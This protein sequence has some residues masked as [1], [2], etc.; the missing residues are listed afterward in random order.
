M[1]QDMSTTYGIKKQVTRLMAGSS[2]TLS[3]LMSML[4]VSLE[5]AWSMAR[6]WLKPRVAISLLLLFIVG[7]GNVWGQDYSGVYY[8]VG[9]STNGYDAGNPANNFYM[10]PTVGYKFYDSVNENYTDTDNG[11][12]FITTYKCR[13][14]AGYDSQEAVWIIEKHPTQDYYYIKHASDGKYLTYNPALFSDNVGRVRVHLETSHNNDDDAALFAIE[15]V[16]NKSSYDIKSKK[17]I[18]NSETRI[19][20]N[21]N[22]GNKQNL[23]GDGDPFDGVNTGGIIGLWTSGSSGDNN[24]KFYLESA[25]SIDAPTITNNNDGTFTITAASEATIYYTTD[26]STPTTTSYTGTG[27][28]SVNIDQTESM[29]VIKAIAKA[30]S[31]PFP[32]NVTTYY[33][34]VCERPVIS[35]SDGIVTITSTTEG[36]TIHYTTDGSPATS[37]S[38]VY[39]G[40]FAKGAASTFRAIA[41][42][43][44]YVTSSEAILLPPT[45]VSSSS[46]ITNMNGSYIL[47]SNF[48][49]SGSIGTADNPFKGIINGKLN[50]LTLGYPL[51]AYAD[52]AT[53]KNVILNNVNIS[54]SN[55]ND[56]GNA[57]AICCEATGD[58]RIYNCGVLSGSV[59]GG[60][61]VGGIVG[62]LDGRA[63]VINCYNYAEIN[64]GSNCGGI[65]GYNN[66]A[67]T[68]NNLQTMVMNCMNYGSV[69]GGNAAPI[70]GGAIIHNKYA[71]AD[72]TGLNNYC[73]FLY[74]EEKV[75]YVKTI[76]DDK[77]NGALGAEERFLNRFEFFRMTLNSTRNLAAFYVTGDATQKNEM[78]KW[79]LDKS[80]APYPILKAQAKYPSVVNPDAAH[81][82]AQ[83]DRN[84][85]GLLGTLSVTISGVGSGAVFSAPSGATITNGSLQ[86]NI[87]DKD[88]DNFNYNYRKVQLPYYNEVGTGNYTK[89]SD[90]TGR[91]VTGWKITS[92]TGGTPGS[93]KTDTYDYPSFNFVDRKCTNK[94]LYGTNGSNRVFAQGAYWEVPDGV[95]AIE[96]EPY[97]AK[98]VYL[99]DANY[100]MTYNISVSGSSATANKYGVTVC[101]SC[102]TTVNGQTVYN[103]ITTATN[104]LGSDASHTVYDYAVVLVGNYHQAANNAI[105]SIGKPLTFMSADL[106]GD[107]EPDNTL[108]YYHNQR[109]RV[110]EIRFDFLN[111]PGIGMVKRTHDATTAPEPGIFKPQG[112]F[113]ITNTV[114]IHC[115]Q[116]EYA[117]G[118]SGMDKTILAPLILQGGVY[119]QFVSGMDAAAKNTN[120]ILIGSNAWFKNFAN[121]C[122]TKNAQKTPK[123]PINVAGGDYTNFY[124]TGIYQPGANQDEE[125]AEC[126]IDGGRF[127]EVAGSGMQ[128]VKG[129]VTWLINAA[130]ITSFF[131][132]GIN[133][134]K[135]IT[136]SIRTTISNSYVDEFYG[137]PKFGDMSNTKTVTTNATDCHFGKFFGA[138]YG[139]TAYNRVGY[140][141]DNSANDTRDW[142]GYVGTHYGR[143]Y[144]A[145]NKGISTNYEYEFIPHSDGK[146]TVARFFVNYASLS[147]ASTRDVTNTLS[148][149]TIGTFYG[150][151]SLG[152][153]NGNINST[154]T[155]CKVTGSTFGAGFSASV[156][157]VEV[158]NK[159]AYLTPN[160]SYNRTANVYN[161]ANVKT[162]KDNNQF[163]VYTWS[164]TYGTNDE[165]FTD[166]EDGK[167]YIHTDV[168]LDGLGAV[169]GNVI[170]TINGNTVADENGKVM[171][172]DHSVYGGGEESAVNGNTS[173]T[174][175]GGTI[176]TTIGTTVLGGAEYGNVFGGGK[177]KEDDVTAG[178][179]KGTTEV[180]IRN[181]L[182][183]Q[184]YVDAHK[185][186]DPNLKVGDVLSSPTILH[187]VY[188]GGAYGSVG[189]FTYD[190]TSGMPT[191][192]ATAN[193]GKTVVTITGGTIGTDGNENGMVF[194]SSRGLEG[195]PETNA[196]VD[197]MAW[198]YDT[199]VT[200]GTLGSETGP[201]IKGSVYGGGENGHNFHDASVTVHSGTIGIVS[202]EKV[203]IGDIEYEGARY[204]NRGNVYGSGCG[205]DTYTGTDSK[206]YFGFNA[207]IVRGN[208]TV[209][210]DGGHV[211]HNVYG[212]G[213]MGSV[214]TYT[215]VDEAYNTAHPEATLPI[216]KPISCAANT[217]TCTV[218]VSGGQIGVAGA[219]MAGHGKGGPDDFGHVFGAGRGEMHDPKL[220]PNVET[221]AY[222]NKTILNISGTAFLTGSAYGGSESGHVLGNT[223]V[224]ISGGQIGCGKNATAPFDKVWADDYVPTAS[225]NLDCASWPFESPFAPYDPFANATGDL[226][227]YP[228]GKSTEGGRLE[229][230]DGHT[231]YGNVFG[232]GSGSVPYFDTT[233]GISKYLSTA[234]SVEGKTTINITGGHI[235]TNVYG[236]CEATNVKGSATITMTG[237]TVGV[238][239]TVAQIVAHPLTG[240]IFGAGKG[241]QRIFFNKETNVDRTFVN[242]EGGRVYGSIFGGGEDGHVFQN[243]TVNIGKDNDTTE[244][245]TIGTTGTSYVD[246]NVF[247]GGRGFGGEALTAGN[248]GGSVELNIKSGKILGSVYG[249]GRLASVGYGLYLVDEEITEGEGKVKPYGIL[250]PDDQYDGSY[251]DPSTDP[252][253]TYYNKG[254]GYITINIS[255]GT[256]GNDLEYIYNPTADQKAAIPYTTFD[257]QNH[258]Q[259]TKGG[260]VFTGGMG[261]LYALDNSTLLTLWPK[262]GKC[263]GT[264]LNMTGGIVKSS[265]YGGGEIG[266][267]EG[268]AT[269]NINGGTVGT[270]VVDSEDATK[271]YYFGSVFGGGK[272]S[273]ANVEGISEAGT[274]GGNVEVN[275]NKT[276]ASD[277]EAKGAIVNQVF[278]CNDM[279]GS[280]KGNVTVHVYA[281]QSPDGD[282]IS[283]KPTKGTETFDVMAVYGGGNL[284][285]YEPTD[286]E[287][288]KTT[289]IIDGCGLTSVRQVYGGGNAASTPATD[290]EVNGTYEILELFGGGNGF[291]KLPNGDSNP[292]ANVG[293]KDY[294]LVEE[295]FPTKED[296]VSG[297]AFAPYRYGTGLATVNIKGGTIHR[298]F[299]GSNTKGNVRE[300]A[301]TMLEEVSAGGVPLC[302]FCVDEA[303]GGGKSAPMDAEAKLLMACIPGLNEVY[304]GAEAA[305]IHD[306]VTL[307]ITNGTFNRVFGG[308]NISGTI[309]GKIT[310]NV[311]ETGCRPVI[312]GELYG[313]GNLAAYSIYGYNDDDTPKESGDNPFDDPVVNVR[314]FTSIGAVYG[315][316]YGTGA[317][318]IASPTVNINESLGTPDNYPTS[319]DYYNENGFAGR[320][321][322]LDAGKPTEHTVTLPAHTKGK[323]GAIG[324][325]FGGGNAAE[326]KGNTTVNVGTLSENTFVSVADVDSTPNTDES[327]STVV[328]VD[329]RGNVYG[330]G[331]NAEVTGDTH[332]TIGKAATATP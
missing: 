262:L 119:E 202:G 221:C 42:K 249:G 157:T 251:P 274:T 150:G 218:T 142:D 208:T 204:P 183:D 327:K 62:L 271:Y 288:G 222:F 103:D 166:T 242:I 209:L 117:A 158:W 48:T 296:R 39:T 45:E 287:T 324:D 199:D 86:L 79:V 65:V 308:N 290:V 219:T 285:A 203:T 254:R 311:E 75:P 248:I 295:Q 194:G 276:V 214:G 270:K 131:G 185:T 279:N 93:F 239:R 10:C 80:I 30:T 66:V 76:A 191:A 286:L 226:D 291:D 104:N 68:S 134:A 22:K 51:V 188:G 6:V 289:V 275:L 200:I 101:G 269:V 260:N 172:V 307:T 238:P 332:V 160:P 17:A 267:V 316:G 137:G 126:Y 90:G 141:D 46:Q 132:G 94:D 18:N 124:L 224:N 136:G 20:L 168:S 60:N 53:I 33:L 107:N 304:G 69:T 240:Y 111:I 63:R 109:K 210:I 181:V 16:S 67:S 70:Y 329:I 8:I 237:G 55:D 112:W 81:A 165:P 229:A 206:T 193:T 245:P 292:G 23:K 58:T 257:Y 146:Q 162:P 73:Y 258:L 164:K 152:A 41:A 15:Y 3:L 171:K 19:F 156:P 195:N 25:I 140:E 122:H 265:V 310:V 232:G 266:A 184:A 264:T 220:Y 37:D 59:G 241:D 38:P 261:R 321:I 50:T 268:N 205:T 82:T 178:L 176:G 177:G 7:S 246:G 27:T 32:T 170:L 95:T 314:S 228:N 217:G 305:D 31:D 250:R 309:S 318:M 175:T 26:G 169:T 116:F 298:V 74:D 300:T 173:V 11:Q 161:N 110:S 24:G 155:N 34:P 9:M 52:G 186:E 231:Y 71:S 57:G 72:D 88:Y 147:L 225:V 315:G 256:I 87:T 284:A 301:L 223:E 145:D 247:G 35:V 89:A 313:G 85:G 163:V 331:N 128:Q 278:G 253:S 84:K 100:D 98:A 207:G 294:H 302:G 227:K 252:A 236:G 64:S 280:P 230:S 255:G 244:G 143:A 108:F 5:A 149:C 281:T 189:T 12:P 127:S 234:G 216:G 190:T 198:V 306:D 312:I 322:T 105:V 125:N 211:V 213:A 2:H 78:A 283:T 282:D 91:V 83:T 144:S 96:I 323:I 92:I 54:S 40:P 263:K 317:K 114:L 187:N 180:T 49:S 303:Y 61:N 182:A 44:G 97:W 174:V 133:A 130:D 233:E 154:L 215:L 192:L 153:V 21:I 293:Y 28:T 1:K 118:G 326:V 272:G 167:H 235:L 328:G 277:D 14:T 243:T 197:K 99:S 129:D 123:V 121:G 273:T 56:N 330:G 102:P 319:G 113:E 159:D 320:T 139:G 196:N 297:D 43:T 135:P 138:G 299:G 106:D 29:T 259:Y 120:Y 77:Y 36:A 325:V 201:S 212:G 4:R 13:G 47:A 151:G 179:V 115:G 148:G